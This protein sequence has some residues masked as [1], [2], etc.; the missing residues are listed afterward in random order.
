[1]SRESCIISCVRR[2]SS[3]SYQSSWC[4]SR[5]SWRNSISRESI[6]VVTEGL[7]FC[8]N[9]CNTTI[10][11]WIWRYETVDW[12]QGAPYDSG[13]FPYCSYLV[14]IVQECTCMCSISIC[15]PV[16]AHSQPQWQLVLIRG[17]RDDHSSTG[18]SRSQGI[19]WY[20]NHAG[21]VPVAHCGQHTSCASVWHFLGPSS[22]V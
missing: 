6:F 19:D 16:P 8:S 20:S 14:F 18:Q 10:R 9:T 21:P 2:R 1:M 13:P 15:D 5:A 12:A 7:L 11:Y 3:P 22:W 17:H 4:Q